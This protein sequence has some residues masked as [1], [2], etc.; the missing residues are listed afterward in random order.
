MK[1]LLL[2]ILVVGQYV[3]AQKNEPFQLYNKKGQKL[4]TNKLFK[5]LEKGEIILFGE[6]HDNPIAHWLQLKTVKMMHA[7]HSISLGAEMLEANNQK[8]IN[9]YLTGTITQEVL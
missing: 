9:D 5:Q 6:L 7:R 3:T 1:Y 2:L 4:N 8:Q